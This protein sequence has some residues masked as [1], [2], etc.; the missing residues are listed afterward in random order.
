MRRPGLVAAVSEVPA[1][2]VEAASAVLAGPAAKETVAVAA[3]AVASDPRASLQKGVAVQGW[4]RCT[5]SATW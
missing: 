1:A 4:A 5:T 3:A 2:G